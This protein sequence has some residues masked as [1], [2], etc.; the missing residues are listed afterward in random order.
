M[1]DTVNVLS[2]CHLFQG[3]GGFNDDMEVKGIKHKDESVLYPEEY[4]YWFMERSSTENTQIKSDFEIFGTALQSR[5][6]TDRR[7]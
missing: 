6:E 5:D 1:K 3:A 7:H 2:G 4:L